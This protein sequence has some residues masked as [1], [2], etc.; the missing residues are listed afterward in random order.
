VAYILNLLVSLNKLNPEEAKKRQRERQ[1]F[2]VKL[3]WDPSDFSAK[4]CWRLMPAAA[5]AVLPVRSNP[6]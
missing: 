2:S 6:T 1:H 3:K 4:N 5:P